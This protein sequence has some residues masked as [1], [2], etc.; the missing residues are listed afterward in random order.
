MVKGQK[1]KQLFWIAGVSLR[2]QDVFSCVRI[3]VRRAPLNACDRIILEFLRNSRAN[4]PS[5]V[6]IR[7]PDA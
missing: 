7:K 1:T 5:R 2:S 6:A 3:T 4:I